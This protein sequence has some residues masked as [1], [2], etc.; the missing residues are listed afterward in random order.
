MFKSDETSRRITF[1]LCGNM[2]YITILILLI[3]GLIWCSITLPVFS[4][5]EIWCSITP[6]TFSDE[7]WCSITPPTVSESENKFVVATDKNGYTVVQVG[8]KQ[9][10]ISPEGNVLIEPDQWYYIELHPNDPN[11][12]DFAYT[13]YGLC[14]LIGYDYYAVY[15]LT[16]GSVVFDNG[17][18][19]IKLARYGSE[20]YILAY[21]YENEDVINWWMESADDM[22]YISVFKWS[23]RK[24]ILQKQALTV[25][26]YEDSDVMMCKIWIKENDGTEYAVYSMTGDHLFSV[27][28]TITTGFQDGFVKFR[29]SNGECVQ[30]DNKGERIN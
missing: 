7:I 11:S 18:H 27:D 25:D 1:R 12:V 21:W 22:P 13:D 8:E 2:K 3:A 19:G 23:D 6:S 16:S 4:E 9:S 29:L 20:I 14:L 26:I 30:Y 28:A 5:S 24:L 10:L 15:D 17:Y